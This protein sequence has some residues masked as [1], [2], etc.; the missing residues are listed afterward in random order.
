MVEGHSSEIV[1][2]AKGSE[3]VFATVGK[4][5]IIMLWLLKRETDFSLRSHVS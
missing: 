1:L 5:N 3:G 4:D 2:L